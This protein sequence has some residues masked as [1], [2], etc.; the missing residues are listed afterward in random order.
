MSLQLKA[1]DDGVSFPVRVVPRAQ[2]NAVGGVRDGAL[3]V[4][5][6]APPVEGRANAALQDFLAEALGVRRNQVSIRTGEKS[7]TKIVRVDG[8][9]PARLEPLLSEP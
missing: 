6:T 3:V 9:G 8:I 7:R 5:L 1:D 4:R 2:R